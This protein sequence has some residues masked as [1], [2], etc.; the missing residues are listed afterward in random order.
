MWDKKGKKRD[1]K[2][3]RILEEEERGIGQR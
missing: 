3:I 2:E 1:G